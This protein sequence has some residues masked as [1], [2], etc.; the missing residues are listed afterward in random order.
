MPTPFHI[1]TD[2][3][4]RERF[5]DNHYCLQQTI[6]LQTMAY[7]AGLYCSILLKINLVPI[8]DK[9]ALLQLG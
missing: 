2:V 3:A 1:P 5:E 9:T 7:D 8:S 4:T 6:G